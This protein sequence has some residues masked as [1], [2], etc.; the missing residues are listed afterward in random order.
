M[1]TQELG[2]IKTITAK[3]FQHLL[4]TWFDQHGRKNLPWQKLKTPYRVWISE[5]M[6]QQTQVATV[7]PYFERFMQRFPDLLSLANAQEDEVLYFWSGLGYYSRAR[8]LLRTAKLLIKRGGF[9]KTIAE[10]SMLP[11]IG[12]STA[13]AIMAIAFNQRAAILDGNV[14]RVLS[15][16]HAI[17]EPI[18]EKQ[19][20]H[21]LW[22]IAEHYV[23]NKHCGDYV[24]AMM[25]L[26]ATICRRNNPQCNICPFASYCLA[27]AQNIAALLPQKKTRRALPIKQ[28]TF[29]I[30]KEKKRLFLF[31]RPP[32]GIWGGLWSFPELPGAPET[33]RIREFCHRHYSLSIKKYENLAGFRHTFTHFHLDIYPILINL[34]KRWKKMYHENEVWYDLKAPHSLGLPRPVQAIIQLIASL[35]QGNRSRGYSRIAKNVQP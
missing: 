17:F 18:D 22:A 20:E 14:K 13:G 5:I 33:Q 21:K 32:N 6:L 29:I 1:S 11:G 25:D 28:S 19:T 3:Q 24:Q 30:F 8:N 35:S 12:Q 27:H 10:L 4:L 9:P 15:R 7:I 26:G 34:Q 2:K 23:P 31:K 16:L